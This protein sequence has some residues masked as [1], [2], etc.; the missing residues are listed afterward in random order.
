MDCECSTIAF[1]HLLSNTPMLRDVAI[2]VKEKNYRTSFPVQDQHSNISFLKIDYEDQGNT[3][4]NI[5]RLMPELQNLQISTNCN[6]LNPR[7]GLNQFIGQ[8]LRSLLSLELFIRS[9]LN[10]KPSE[11]NDTI[12]F[13]NRFEAIALA[14]HLTRYPLRYDYIPSQHYYCYQFYTIP[15]IVSRLGHLFNSVITNSHSNMLEMIG[16]HCYIRITSVEYDDIP[17]SEN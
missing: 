17:V 14:H 12:P 6:V 15:C 9:T 10:R 5:L 1:V 16:E 8:S 7:Y 4:H 13:Y 11:G 2:R 3:L